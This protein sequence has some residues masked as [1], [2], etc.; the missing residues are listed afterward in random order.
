MLA[1]YSIGMQEVGDDDYSLSHLM[2]LPTNPIE[3]EPLF[4]NKIRSYYG[5]P[6]GEYG[7]YCR[8]AIGKVYEDKFGS[9]KEAEAFVVDG[10]L[11]YVSD[12][13]VVVLGRFNDGT[14]IP[15]PISDLVAD[16]RNFHEINYVSYNENGDPVNDDIR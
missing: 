5:V 15:S 6:F 10:G 13:G 14:H 8:V 2:P 9:L 7:V 12:D 4:T 3:M 1:L 16:L 11:G